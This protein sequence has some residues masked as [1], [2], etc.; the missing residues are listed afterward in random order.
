MNNDKVMIRPPGYRQT[1]HAKC[2]RNQNQLA[3]GCLNDEQCIND[4][5]KY[6]NCLIAL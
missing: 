5:T 1:R 3:G 4:N 2:Y 6:Y